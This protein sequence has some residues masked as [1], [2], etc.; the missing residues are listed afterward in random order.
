MKI[1]VISG[2]VLPLFV[3]L[4]F[5]EEFFISDAYAYLDPSVGSMFI[6]AIVGALVGVGITLKIYWKRIKYALLERKSNEKK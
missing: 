4:L 5:F 1:K 3:I 6:Q 2:L